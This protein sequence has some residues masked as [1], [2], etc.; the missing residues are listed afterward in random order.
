MPSDEEPDSQGPGAEARADE[1]P[2]AP[3]GSGQ[4]PQEAEADSDAKALIEGVPRSKY[5]LRG[6]AAAAQT[7]LVTMSTMLSLGDNVPGVETPV[8]MVRKPDKWYKYLKLIA[9][10]IVEQDTKFLLKK[11]APEEGSREEKQQ[12]ATTE[13]GRLLVH[14]LRKVEA[15]FSSGG[16]GTLG[17]A[18]GRIMVTT[19]TAEER[20]HTKV[21]FDDTEQTMLLSV[22]FKMYNRQF[23]KTRVPT[24]KVMRKLAYWVQIAKMWPDPKIV[25]L[26]DMQRYANDNEL[27]N[28]RRLCVG[29]C[30]VGA[31]QP[32]PKGYAD[33]GAGKHTWGQGRYHA[34]LANVD[35]IT[36]LLEELETCYWSLSRADFSGLVSALNDML[37]HVSPSCAER[38]LTTEYY[39]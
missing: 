28:F 11:F 15:S 20:N 34:Q 6:L 9:A 5:I 8:S 12:A 29:V 16:G 39:K 33:D 14:L 30:I 17:S 4:R 19:E 24:L 22:V 21:S 35:V 25:Q 23:E 37:A 32:V 18:D 13:V 26:S 10:E 36:R 3:R 38:K 7:K 2:R 1:A 27:T 31:N